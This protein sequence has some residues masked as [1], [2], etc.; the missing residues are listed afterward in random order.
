MLY[1]SFNRLLNESL[2]RRA[3]L[4]AHGKAKPLPMPK[5]L[6]EQLPE[7]VAHGRKEA[8]RAYSTPWRTRFHADG[9]QHSKLMADTCG[10]F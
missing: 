9:G 2:N 3:T 1:D 8:E 6:L 10:V 5:S 7:I 4:A